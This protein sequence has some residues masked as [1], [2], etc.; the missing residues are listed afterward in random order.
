MIRFKDILYITAIDKEIKI[1]EM[2]KDR[3]NP[4]VAILKNNHSKEFDNI[5]E[6]YGEYKFIKQ[7][8]LHNETVFYIKK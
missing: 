4:L 8:I 2:T 7:A 3:K 1:I 6:E 5:Y